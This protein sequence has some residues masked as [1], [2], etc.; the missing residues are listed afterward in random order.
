VTEEQRSRRPILIAT[1][2]AAR[3]QQRHYIS[4]GLGALLQNALKDDRIDQFH[5]LY[6]KNLFLMEVL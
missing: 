2:R 5:K 1:R 4:N 3:P 6:I